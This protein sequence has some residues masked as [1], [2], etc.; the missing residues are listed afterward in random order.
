MTIISDSTDLG[1]QVYPFLQRSPGWEIHTRSVCAEV[2]ETSVPTL[3]WVKDDKI[4]DLFIPHQT[5]DQFLALSGLTLSM[6]KGPYV[7]SKRISRIMR[8]YRYFQFFQPND[9]LIDHNS[10]LNPVTWDGAGQIS[11]RVIERIAQN[12]DPTHP[13]HELHL[14]ELRHTRRFEITVMHDGGQEK[15]HVMVCDDLAVDIMFPAGSTKTEIALQNRVFV[16][17]Q[18]VHAEE[19]MRLD[20]QSLVNLHP[21]FR[22]EHLLA[23]MEQ[24]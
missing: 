18:P 7:L 10:E 8:P 24:E 23:W 12:L 3:R 11:S 4:C 21:F 19:N 16:G 20:V 2:E 15:G 5:A 13:Y 14:K 22:P 9:I 1:G 6:H 17:L